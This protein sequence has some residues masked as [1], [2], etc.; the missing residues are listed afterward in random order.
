MSGITSAIVF[1]TSG[2]SSTNRSFSEL[3]LLISLDNINKN[4][5]IN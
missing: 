2:G 3:I 4:N 1:I 5:C